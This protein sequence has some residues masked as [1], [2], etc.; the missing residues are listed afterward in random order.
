MQENGSYLGIPLIV[1]CVGIVIRY[2]RKLWPVYLAIVLLASW[3]LSLGPRLIVHGRLHALPFA[4]PFRKLDHL[5]GI[6]SILPVRFS[7]YVVFFAAILVAMA[8]DEAHRTHLLRRSDS[9]RPRPWTRLAGRFLVGILTIA[10]VVTLLPAWPYK[11][12]P[13]SINTSE[14]A[15]SLRIIPTGSVVVT[16]P[17]PTTFYDA[18]MLWQALDGMR[19]KLVGGYALVPNKDGKASIF[20]HELQP[21]IVES[22]LV[23]SVSP[24]TVPG[25]PVAIATAKTIAASSV[26]V[27]HSSSKWPS[28]T[29]RSVS[30]VVIAAVASKGMIYIRHGYSP[31]AIHVSP[32]TQYV[33]RWTT[34]P[35]LA[36]IVPGELIT[37]TGTSGPGT[38][39]PAVVGQ[40]REFLH[41]AHVQAVIVGLG[42]T[43]AGVVAN[44][45][46]DALGPP[47]RAGG[48]AEI[49]TN[50]NV[51]DRQ[52]A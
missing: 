24:V 46:R 15:A 1:V 20:P 33:E 31:I 35:S 7:L 17:Y 39:T 10:T 52:G 23:N 41:N 44:W 4:L 9:E 34:R 32:T 42:T 45:F 50:V 18:P 26:A 30:G 12:Y 19:F 38:V 8:I 16:Y 6:D 21:S 3:L 2:W 11:S 27:L 37:A 5:P 13:V 14:R 51:T 43:D 40:L 48:G 36:G 25:Y 29:A 47:A 22:M 28:D 49:W